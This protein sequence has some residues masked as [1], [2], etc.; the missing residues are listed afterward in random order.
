MK[1][2]YLY[3]KYE[4]LADLLEGRSGI[5]FSDLSH[6]SRLENEKMRDDEMKKIFIPKKDG[7]I[8]EINGYRV[9]TNDLA[10]D[11]E[12]SVTPRHCYCLCLSSKGNDEGL[13]RDFKADT[14]I[15][16]NVDEL[17]KRI[18]LSC[19]KFKGSH[20]VASDITYYDQKTLLGLEQSPEKL[21]FYKPDFFAHESEY[22]IA[23]FYPLN[24]TGFLVDG[25]TIPFRFENESSHL[26][27]FHKEKCFIT[28]C[29][30]D[31]YT[32]S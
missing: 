2:K 20:I 26:F 30:V 1:I 12:L 13:Y 29:I 10:S 25:R 19:E 31:I 8:I 11:P 24:K 28:G 3:G 18:S 9:D 22:R 23:W 16:F 5:R 17:E 4:F 21:V 7:L 15:A 32:K 14:C 27:I 6:Y